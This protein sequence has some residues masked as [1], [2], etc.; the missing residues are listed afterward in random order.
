MKT[1]IAVVIALIG[2]AIVS[3]LLGASAGAQE[4]NLRVGIITDMSGQYKDGT[5]RAR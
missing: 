4:N 3:V 1:P 2:C 5:V